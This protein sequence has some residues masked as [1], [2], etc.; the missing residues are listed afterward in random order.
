MRKLV[1][2]LCICF[3][4][5]EAK[6]QVTESQKQEA[7]AAASQFCNLLSQF[8]NGGTQ[9]LGNDQKI[10]AL[11]S[12]RNIS[13]FDDIQQNKEVLLSSYLSLITKTYRNK[14]QFNFSQPTY[15]DG[16][17][18]P[19][20]GVSVVHVINNNEIGIA[21][22]SHETVLDIN[23]YTDIY[24][25]INVDQ[26]IPKLGK[27][28]KRK[29]IY[30]IN[31]KRIISFSNNHSPYLLMQKGL[32]EI[33]NK[34]YNQSISF[35]KQAIAYPR[36]TDKQTCYA[37]MAWAESILGNVDAVIECYEKMDWPQKRGA[38]ALMKASKAAK[39]E[40][41]E[42]VFKYSRI[43]ADEGIEYAYYMLGLCYGSGIEDVCEQNEE[44]AKFYYKKAANSKTDV[45]A[46]TLGS[47]YLC[48]AA[49]DGEIELS[50][51]EYL[52]YALVCVKEG[53]TRIYLHLYQHYNDLKQYDECY[54]WATSAA[55]LGDRNGMALAGF[56]AIFAKKNNKEGIEWLRKSIDGKLLETSKKELEDTEGIAYLE[57]SSTEEVRELIRLAENNQESNFNPRF[58]YSLR[59][60]LDN[61]S[62]S[63]SST[64]T[65]SQQSRVN[66]VQS[67][68]NVISQQ[69]SNNTT[70]SL[71]NY[72]NYH[73]SNKYRHPF[74]SPCDNYFIGFSAGYVQKQWTFD[75]KEGGSEKVGFWDDSKQISGVQAGI[76]VNPQFGYGFGLNT[77]LYYEYYYSKSDRMNYADDYGQYTGTLQEHALYLP[78]HLEYRMN[79]S[80]YFQLFFY[81]G[82]GL[83][84]GLANSIKWVDCDDDSY[85]E[86]INNIYD[87]DDCP[88]WQRFNYSLEYGGGI[89][90]SRFQLNF[91][92]SKGLRNMSNTDEYKVYQGKNLMLSISIM[93]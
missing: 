35:F 13:A 2:L 27:T 5:M 20:F 49:D 90:T 78:V 87:S 6:S 4:S 68:T 77:G 7:L 42:G 72:T 1:V 29:I 58:N 14:I 92:M 30:S 84:Y 81:C 55:K 17:K 9:Y 39:E 22:G 93:L 43:A 11:C 62:T 32:V 64:S 15:S 74:N 50:D 16:F 89:R 47:Y 57:L 61:N 86:T 80:N 3:L 46:R 10:F 33:S 91:T 88:D 51:E 41:Y 63:S 52:A 44:L 48:C 21:T 71:P 69:V 85:S 12:S 25:V 83:D 38:I 23:G 26:T 34:N 54:N 60:L 31:S 73:Y 76:R 53:Y 59:D 36:F 37:G 70:N 67:D 28:T 19:E 8:S 18:I 24:I 65:D 56:Y 40:D 82:I 75:Y 45:V 79:F 66:N